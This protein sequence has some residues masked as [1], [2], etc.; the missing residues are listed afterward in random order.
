MKR[1]EPTVDDDVRT[2]GGQPRSDGSGATDESPSDRASAFLSETDYKMSRADALREYYDRKFYAPLR[3]ILT[4][5]RGIVGVLVLLTYLLMGTV[6]VVL[7]PRPMQSGPVLLP[8]FTDWTYPLGTDPSGKGLF[9]MTVHATPRMLQMMLGGALFGT[10]MTIGIGTISGFKR[11]MVDRVMMTIS[12]TGQ[13]L[14][15]MPI[16]L[17]LVAIFQPTNPFLVGVVL[18]LPGALGGGR[19]I[20]AQT[21]QI[22]N[23]DFVEAGRAMGMTTSRNIQVH[24]LPELM[25]KITIGFMMGLKNVIYAAVGLYFL[26]ILPGDFLNWGMMLNL[27]YS[28]VNLTSMKDIH[29]LMVP[30]LV[31][32]LFG[33]GTTLMA[34][35]FDRVYNPRL[36]AKHDKTLVG[37]GEDDEQSADRAAKEMMMR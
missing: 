31:I 32:S 35:A 23:E 4:D 5:Y 11:G 18:S 16:L 34:Q 1:S 33:F 7:V 12:D 19:G 8:W 28:E 22:R 17:V 9:R 21:L 27:S 14:P 25:P 26:G 10:A 13:N 6:G 3:I 2:D 24:V 37:G 29:Y 20:R 36:R 15:G 30:M